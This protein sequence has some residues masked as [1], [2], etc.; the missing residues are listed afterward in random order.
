MSKFDKKLRLVDRLYKGPSR[1]CNST[2]SQPRQNVIGNSQ[3]FVSQTWKKVGKIWEEKTLITKLVSSK[4]FPLWSDLF[5]SFGWVPKSLW[6]IGY[7]STFTATL[8]FHFLQCLSARAIKCLRRNKLHRVT[9]KG[10][11][12]WEW[13]TGLVQVFCSISNQFFEMY[14]WEVAWRQ[15]FMG[16]TFQQ[17]N[18]LSTKATF[19]THQSKFCQWLIV[20]IFTKQFK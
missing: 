19:W 2:D 13:E 5:C 17:T 8:F 9:L 15:K 12:H 20:A 4:L 18:H 14:W 6:H 11:K 1:R 3:P 10:N 7:G 16:G